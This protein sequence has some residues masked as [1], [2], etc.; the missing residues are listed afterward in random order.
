MKPL[1]STRLTV[2]FALMAGL[3]LAQGGLAAWIANRA[4]DQVMRGRVAGDLQSGFWELSA[5]KQRLR[6]WSL[7][8]LIG[9]PH[10]AGDGEM[11]R[12]RMSDTV[13]RLRALSARAE[14]M[15]RA[16]GIAS[17][18]AARRDDAL[19]VL[20]ASVI[21]LKQPIGEINRRDPTQDALTAWGEIESVFDTGAGRDLREMLNGRIQTEA[22]ILRQT[23][24]TADVYLERVK[25]LCWTAAATL[26]LTSLFLAFYFI[27]A[28]RRP[29]AAMS[30][31]ARAFEQGRLDHR[32]P[33]D[34]FAEFSRLGLSINQMAAEL[35]ASREQEADLRASL[36]VQVAARTQELEAAL[37]ELRNVEARRRQLLGDISH[38]LR[39]PMTAI[40]G[41]ADVALRG[42]KTSEDYRDALRRITQASSQMGALI[43]DLLMMARSD[44][45]MLQ[46][47]L[48]QIDPYEALEAA[49]ATLSP[50]AHLRELDLRVDSG[51]G[52][53]RVEADPQRLQQ[54]IA[55]LLDNAIR[56]SHPGGTIEVRAGPAVE[57]DRLWRLEIRDQGIGIAEAD[58]GHVFE[59]GFR[60]TAARAHR[61]DGT[62]LGLPIARTLTERQGGGLA[63]ESGEGAGVRA[64]LTLPRTDG[65]REAG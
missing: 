46:L 6:A 25:L 14:Q 4:E 5:T 26:V 1:F 30:E 31:G 40:R 63:L 55:L 20:A 39:T 27:R 2:A 48:A 58:L 64:T 38:E 61:A 65:A 23:R 21:A 62:G 54:V 24:K 10:G 19:A 44:A 56:Y 28:L 43:E 22:E 57:D 35:S 60:S 32:M 18:E 36:E 47:D 17:G 13:V 3:A 50:V 9:A 8:A 29:L 49:L 16:A 59:R 11:L 37:G 51:P 34:G 7:R 52:A 45:E 41:E 53:T 42:R 15:D 12:L 33:E